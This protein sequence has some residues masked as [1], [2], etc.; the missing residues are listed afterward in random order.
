VATSSDCRHHAINDG[1]P[2]E[3]RMTGLLSIDHV[4]ECMAAVTDET[5]SLEDIFST[6]PPAIRLTAPTATRAS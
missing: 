1:S 3:L 6:V 4:E 5:T 2:L